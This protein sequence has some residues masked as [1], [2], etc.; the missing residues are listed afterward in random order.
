MT[1]TKLVTLAGMASLAT[2]AFN[3][4]NVQA[5]T[6]NSDLGYTNGT[7]T[8]KKTVTPGGA[9]EVVDPETISPS[10]VLPLKPLEEKKEVGNDH[11]SLVYY[12]DFNFGEHTYQITK[13]ATYDALA[14]V[15][16]QEDGTQRAVPNFVQIN[17]S[18]K[19][20]DWKIS[21]KATDFAIE[22]TPKTILAGASINLKNVTVNNQLGNQATTAAT[23]Y[24][25]TPGNSVTIGNYTKP[26]DDTYNALSINSIVFGTTSTKTTGEADESDEA[27]TYNPGVQL[28]LPSGMSIQNET[29]TADLEWTMESTI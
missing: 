4:V 5:A 27:V 3:S 2:L 6:D 23:E 7:V 13:A 12:P 22:G 29:Y 9:A 8:L 11:V 19:A 25:L 1:T 20:K 21:V 14:P 17:N 26:E 15:F 10:P 18:P 16:Q 24:T 28:T